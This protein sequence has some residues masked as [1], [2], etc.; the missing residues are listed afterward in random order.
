MRQ[1]CRGDLRSAGTDR[2]DDTRNSSLELS[3]AEP[4]WA[5]NR[6]RG[7]DWVARTEREVIPAA[8]VATPIVDALGHRA[9][10]ALHPLEY[11]SWST[12]RPRA[13]CR[14]ISTSAR[15][16]VHGAITYDADGRA[17]SRYVSCSRAPA[18]V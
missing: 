9:G 14:T 4:W 10:A 11:R 1:H 18:P 16:P 13:V 3:S 12:R 8:G 2:T 7:R 6:A 15:L 5:S 17:A